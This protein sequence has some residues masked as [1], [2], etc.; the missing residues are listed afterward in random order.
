MTFSRFEALA[1][2]LV[3]VA[4]LVTVALDMLVWRAV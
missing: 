4:A 3:L 2:R 1:F